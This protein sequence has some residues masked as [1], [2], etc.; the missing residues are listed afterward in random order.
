MY[1][2][3]SLRPRVVL[4]LRVMMGVVLKVVLALQKRILTPKFRQNFSFFHVFF[5]SNIEPLIRYFFHCSIFYPFM[6]HI[7]AR[8][9][10]QYISSMA[11]NLLRYSKTTLYSN[12]IFF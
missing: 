4:R 2:T 10:L 9:A 8:I 5:L 6:R 7:T 3:D 1:S 11:H 12:R